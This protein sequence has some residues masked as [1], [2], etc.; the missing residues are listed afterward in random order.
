MSQGAVFTQTARAKVNLTLHV[1]R[2]I[3]DVSDAYFGYHPLD[4]LVVFADVG[5]EITARVSDETSLSI[6]GPFAQGLTAGA[7]NLILKALEATAAQGQCQCGC[8]AADVARHH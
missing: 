2:V 7:D 8:G 5:D 4:S 6:T 1:G 3:A